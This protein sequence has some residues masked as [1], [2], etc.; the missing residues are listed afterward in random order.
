MA[1][2]RKKQ[3]EL[4]HITL[5]Y[6][7]FS[8]QTI[9][10]LE[11]NEGVKMSFTVT[12][13]QFLGSS[14]LLTA[15]PTKL[16]ADTPNDVVLRFAVM[17]DIHFSGNT[18]AREV[19]RFEKALRFL[20]EYSASQPYSNFDLLLIAGDVSN[21]GT[22]NEIDLFKAKLDAGIRPGTKVMMCMGNHEFWGGNRELWEKTFEQPSNNRIEV[23]GYQFIA[24]SPEKGTMRNGDYFYALSWLKSELDA[25]MDTDEKKPVFMIQHYHITPTVYGSRDLDNNGGT[26][27]LFDILQGYPRVVDFSGH[28]HFPIN[29]PRSVWQGEFTAFGTGTLSYFA[30]T[31]GRY[32]SAPKGNQNAA[33]FYIVEV[34]RDH[35]LVVRPYDI[36]TDS[37]FD[38]VLTVAEP[39][40]REKYLYTDA[41]Y[42]TSKKPIWKPNTRLAVEQIDAY[43]GMFRFEQA[44]GEDI[45]HS[46]RLDFFVKRGGRW[47]KDIEKYVWSEYYFKE[48][49]PVME[50]Y[51][52]SLYPETE[53]RVEIFAINPYY[54]VSDA[55][56]CA[57][58][59]TISDPNEK[60]DKNAESPEANI[61]D[62]TFKDGK[63]VNAPVNH[64]NE[65]KQVAAFGAVKIGLDETIGVETANFDGVQARLKIDFTR[66][67]YGRLTNRITQAVRFKFDQFEDKRVDVLFANTEQG[68]IGLEIRH[69]HKSLEFWININR[70]YVVLS[71][72][73]EPGTWHTAFGV[74]DGEKVTLY[75]DGKKTAQKE[76]SGRITYT[77]NDKSR[78]FC[79]GSDIGPE[80]NGTEFF[81]GS[82]AMAR[83]YN[84]ALTEQQVV[85]LSKQPENELL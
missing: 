27:D 29:D 43:G 26:S 44:I 30:M 53:Y 16:F 8:K 28:S 52:D 15:I 58:F 36:I 82:I 39:G 10:D 70:E 13:R 76:V 11:K 9:I 67:E 41:R 50:V 85:N 66:A 49:P 40:N 57:E 63:A 83:L 38:Y 21:H 31:D 18:Q 12:R 51:V 65:Q 55:S 48:M 56:I 54:K 34:H 3:V 74:Y 37:F 7:R 69:E 1:V 64:L 32:E 61:L 80:G 17:S 79:I 73:V 60:V 35:S 2:Q 75:L 14:L 42:H 78:A 77:T 47:V 81:K 72:P 22:S 62:V 24:L 59:R 71:S 25:A 6:G 5:H 68:G 84:W 19:A 46:Y 23:N 4:V 45:V 33:Q 20:N